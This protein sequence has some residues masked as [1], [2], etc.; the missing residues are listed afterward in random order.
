MRLSNT[1]EE[2]S[3]VLLK[4]DVLGQVPPKHSGLEVCVQKV[5]WGMPWKQH[6]GELKKQKW[7]KIQDRQRCSCHRGA[8]PQ[9]GALKVGWSNADERPGL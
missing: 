7:A 5:Y 9:R 2:L 8:T 4:M 6:C 3:H 1:K